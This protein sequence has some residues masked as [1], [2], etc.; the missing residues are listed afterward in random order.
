MDLFTN[1]SNSLPGFNQC[2][3]SCG[4]A[5][6]HCLSCS[7][8]CIFY[9]LAARPLSDSIYEVFRCTEWTTEVS[10]TIL[11]RTKL[12]E[13]STSL[14][15]SPGI[16]RR[17][18]DIS[19]TVLSTSAPFAPILSWNY[20]TDG[21]RI[22][23]T[24]H[25]PPGQ[26]TADS[27]GQLQCSSEGAARSFSCTFRPYI[28]SCSNSISAVLCACPDG[29]VNKYFTPESTL[30]LKREVYS[31]RP[32]GGTTTSLEAYTETGMA[33]QLQVSLENKRLDSVI[34]PNVCSA[35]FTSLNGCYDC[36]G[37]AHATSLCTSTL[38][39]ETALVECEE[40]SK[41]A[42]KCSPTTATTNISLSTSESQPTLDCRIT[43]SGGS[44]EA[45]ISG[46]LQYYI[47]K[48]KELKKKAT[49]YLHS[50]NLGFDFL[51]RLRTLLDNIGK[52]GRY[53]ILT[54]LFVFI[55]Y[56]TIRFVI[57]RYLRY[58]SHR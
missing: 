54:I 35:Q 9:R 46:R 36:L 50:E 25:A 20:V 56:I 33:L 40:G 5:T 4:C 42:I 21:T 49:I 38:T 52:V 37:G 15:L 11:F 39:E 3:N 22:A 55:L 47:R 12:E 30:P 26:Y 53:A 17:W 6:C 1:A 29:D 31:I 8:S 7:P 18:N 16:T 2:M 32:A 51:S 34:Q 10:T 28:C 41:F 13:R 57:Y 58:V 43:C 48:E 14:K 45:S 44:T 24:E 27:V 23:L 19:M